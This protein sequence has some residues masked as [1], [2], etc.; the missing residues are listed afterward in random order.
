ML[1][2]VVDNERKERTI[3]STQMV[4]KRLPLKAYT[5]NKL[6]NQ[7]SMFSLLLPLPAFTFQ[8]LVIQMDALK[9]FPMAFFSSGPFLVVYL[10]NLVRLQA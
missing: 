9:Y 5:I 6:F 7:P 4:F 3:Q 2:I 8:Y 1:K 10:S